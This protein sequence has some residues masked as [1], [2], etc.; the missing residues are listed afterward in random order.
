MPT[1]NSFDAYLYDVLDQ[2]EPAARAAAA[3]YLDVIETAVVALLRLDV[4]Q[5]HIADAVDCIVDNARDLY[6]DEMFTPNP[7]HDAT[8]VID[9]RDV[10][11]PMPAFVEPK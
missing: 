7:A 11:L 5:T 6:A 3:P 9:N 10:T 4:H 2:Y 1:S 8:F